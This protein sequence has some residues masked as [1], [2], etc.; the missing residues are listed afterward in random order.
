M[1]S[2]QCGPQR[3]SGRFCRSASARIY[4]ALRNEVKRQSHTPGL[5]SPVPG[6]EEI[7]MQ[8]IR[9]SA[10]ITAVLLLK[11]D[12]SII[13]R[14]CAYFCYLK[15]IR[16]SK[17]NKATLYSWIL[18]HW[19]KVWLPS[20]G[21]ANDSGTS[22]LAVALALSGPTVITANCLQRSYTDEPQT[23]GVP[24]SCYSVKNRA[25]QTLCK[26]LLWWEQLFPTCIKRA[27]LF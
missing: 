27:I 4:G 12:E 18:T 23:S 26:W 11:K 25:A 5:G 17:K 19:I 1:I 6:R 14:H 22:I 20:R 15:A 13:C 7:P 10:V 16:N 24:E 9:S 3:T 8:T 21:F 2:V